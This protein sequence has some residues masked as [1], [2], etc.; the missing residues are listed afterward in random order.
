MGAEPAEVVPVRIDPE[1]RADRRAQEDQTT[2]SDIIR[3][4]IRRYLDVA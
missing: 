4:A 2:T 3:Q 1:L